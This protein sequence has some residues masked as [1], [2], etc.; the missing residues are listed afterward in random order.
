MHFCSVCHNMYYLKIRDE[1]GGNSLNYYCRNCGHEDT[2]L[3]AESICVSETQL[4]RSEQKYTHMVNEYTKFDP[5]LPRINTIKCP[6]QECSSNGGH[7]GTT[8]MHGGVSDTSDIQSDNNVEKEPVYDGG[9][10]KK[11]AATVATVAE[12]TAKENTAETKKKK[13]A[14]TL[15]KEAAESAAESAKEALASAKK[16]ETIF[17][18]LDEEVAKEEQTMKK[19]K[20]AVASK[21][22]GSEREVIYIRYDDINMKYVYLC[23]HCDTTWKT[24]NRM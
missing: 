11:T 23:V 16:A 4:R 17:K 10:G 1:D 14:K 2:T 18:K 8:A 7:S 24:D 12:T 9:A 21:K 20:S 15:A 13:T 3:T 6:N 22:D 19:S 5:T